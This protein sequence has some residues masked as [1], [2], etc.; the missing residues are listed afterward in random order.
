MRYTIIGDTEEYKDCLIFLTCAATR[1]QAE[2]T[3]DRV[4]HGSEERYVEARAK[5]TNI[6]IEEVDHGW[7]DDEYSYLSTM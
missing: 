1:E 5:H 6:R 7:W 4:L 3:L 2:E